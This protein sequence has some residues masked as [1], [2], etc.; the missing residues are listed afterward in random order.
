MLRGVQVK[1]EEAETLTPRSHVSGEDVL[2]GATAAGDA[3]GVGPDREAGGG[4]LGGRSAHAARESTERVGGTEADDTGRDV[5]RLEHR[6]ELVT[7]SAHELTRALSEPLLGLQHG[8]EQDD[9]GQKQVGG[10]GGQGGARSGARRASRLPRLGCCGT[11][12][13]MASPPRHGA[14]T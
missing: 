10:D 1:E 7:A 3:I 8:S 14:I 4:A 12:A 2:V 11:R 6:P 13:A 9:T 5:A